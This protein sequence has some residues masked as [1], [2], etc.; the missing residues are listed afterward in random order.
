MTSRKRPID[1]VSLGLSH[2][3]FLTKRDLEM[4]EMERNILTRIIYKNQLQFRR[5]DILN[6]LKSLVKALDELYQLRQTNR[7]IETLGMLESASERFFQHVT[8]GLMLTLSMTCVACLARI[9]EVLRRIPVVMELS[10]TY[11]GD[12]GVPV[13]R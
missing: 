10:G 11:N 1:D 4:F 8:M 3:P 5:I 12:E 13:V 2:S 6:R 7:I 9:A